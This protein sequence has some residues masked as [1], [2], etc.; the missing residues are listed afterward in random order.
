MRGTA[1]PAGRAPRARRA[2]AGWNGGWVGG[3][4]GIG[5]E[6][7]DRQVRRAPRRARDRAATV[8]AAAPAPGARAAAARGR[9]RRRV[10]LPAARSEA[11]TARWHAL[12]DAGGV[13]LPPRA[14]QPLPH[15]VLALDHQ[16][17]ACG[18]NGGGRQQQR[19]RGGSLARP[20]DGERAARPP[21][22][23]RARGRGRQ[24]AAAAQRRRGA[25]GRL[26]RG[27]GRA[28]PPGGRLHR[29]G[30]S[31]AAGLA[32]CGSKRPGV[33]GSRGSGGWVW[34]CGRARRAFRPSPRIVVA[35]AR[36]GGR[37][38]TAAG[39]AHPR[40]AGAG[41][42][43]AWRVASGGAVPR[44]RP[45]RRRRPRPQSAGLTGARWER[46]GRGGARPRGPEPVAACAACRC[47]QPAAP[48]PPQAQGRRGASKRRP[49]R[50]APALRA[51]S[52]LLRLAPRVRSQ[53]RRRSAECHRHSPLPAAVQSAPTGVPACARPRRAV[54]GAPRP[55]RR[56]APPRPPLCAIATLS[57]F[58]LRRTLLRRKWRVIA[59]R[60]PRCLRAPRA[61]PTAEMGGLDVLGYLPAPAGPANRGAADL[62]D[63]QL[64][65]CG[66]ASSVL[67]LE[68]RPPRRAPRC[69]ARSP[70]HCAQR[71]PRQRWPGRGGRGEERRQRRSGSGA[72]RSG[73]PRCR[74]RPSSPAPAAPPPRH[75]RPQVPR[76]QVACM[77][78][79]GHRGAAV[80][81]VKWC[82]AGRARG[83]QGR[84]AA[85]GCKGHAAR[86]SAAKSA[87]RRPWRRPRARRRER[88]DS[89]VPRSA[90]APTAT[91]APSRAAA[92]SGAGCAA[93]PGAAAAAVVAAARQQNSRR[94]GA[95]RSAGPA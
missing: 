54:S 21:A 64:F 10:G 8:G 33:Y 4:V 91:P 39:A 59:D 45:R 30:P 9:A 90:G 35:G 20:T 65:A 42:P 17:G 84:P 53:P 12:R 69:R 70:P 80:T 56:P 67:V 50:A 15:L 28:R 6:G 31:Q 60:G 24:A 41:C 87:V 93:R 14:L 3:W 27:R 78:Q 83:P 25:L 86:S 61:P 23:S 26:R 46:R 77:L 63:G 29:E 7:G 51:A 18:R 49:P 76:L 62:L 75:L 57:I 44:S 16:E 66:A 58:V 1:A 68:V 48:P 52:P 5:D 85:L 89:P 55:P 38:G 2:P 73:P 13:S 32:V 88:A 19:Q 43:R 95:L 94:C 37:A 71:R 82:A 40:G 74:R 34:A 72:A 81:A 79:G 47:R 36:P 92:T 11:A 22:A